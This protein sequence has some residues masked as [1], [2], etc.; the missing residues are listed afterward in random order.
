MRTKS[1]FTGSCCA[2]ITPFDKN[3]DPAWSEITKV[4]D[5]LIEKMYFIKRIIRK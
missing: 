2:M 1:V 5:F 3:G 4:V